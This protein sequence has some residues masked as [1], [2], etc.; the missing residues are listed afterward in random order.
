[1]G[2][3]TGREGWVNLGILCIATNI[4][5]RYFDL[6]G[7]MLEGGVFFIVT[8]VLVTGVGIYLEK[9]RRSLVGVLRTEAQS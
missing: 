9:K 7:S 8:G 3:A 5:S 2:L 4:V 1:M 6:F